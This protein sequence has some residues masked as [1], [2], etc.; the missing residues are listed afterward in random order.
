MTPFWYLI[1]ALSVIVGI[2]NLALAFS[3]RHIPMVA[4]VRLLAAIVSFV[5][6]VGIVVGKALAIQN[7]PYLEQWN[8]FLGLGVFVFAVLVLPSYF[9]RGAKSEQ[10]RVTMQQRAARPAN[11][12]VRLRD[13]TSDEWVN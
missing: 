3:R 1:V 4:L 5:P 8:V 13:A 2:I 12:T 11:A 9:E 10:P 7:H 6:A